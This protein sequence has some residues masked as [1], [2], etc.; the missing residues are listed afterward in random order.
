MH[1]ALRE[2]PD[3]GAQVLVRQ[4]LGPL[5]EGAGALDGQDL[6]GDVGE[7]AA[8]MHRAFQAEDRALARLDAE[9]AELLLVGRL[10]AGRADQDVDAAAR[11]RF[12]VADA[13][14][15]LRAQLRLGAAIER[16]GAE[17]FAVAE[18]GHLETMPER[19]GALVGI[20]LTTD[21]ALERGPLAGPVR[22]PRRTRLIHPRKRR[23]VQPPRPPR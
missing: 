6:V 20:E 22:P 23:T 13:Q 9:L 11:R 3:T 8:E 21:R 10:H 14:Q 17:E 5:D 16:P 12:R 4:G 1:P 15:G 19:A 18:P 2:Q 7:I